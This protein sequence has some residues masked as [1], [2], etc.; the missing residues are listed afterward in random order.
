MTE[1]TGPQSRRQHGGDGGNHRGLL[2]REQAQQEAQLG[3]AIRLKN[4]W[5]TRFDHVAS[6][7]RAWR[8]W[9]SNIIEIP[10]F[11]NTEILGQSPGF[12]DPD[13]SMLQPTPSTRKF[14]RQKF[15]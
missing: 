8:V 6:G 2:G 5:R 11:R 7:G 1:V 9:I 12:A 3:T 10:H 14:R 15:F 4:A 13:T